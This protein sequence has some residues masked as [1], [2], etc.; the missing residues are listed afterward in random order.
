MQVFQ[1]I[2]Q[3]VYSQQAQQAPP[4]GGEPQGGE[5]AA[6]EDDVVEGEIVDEGDAEGSG[7]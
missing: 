6:P 2:G 4:G 7:S 5:G 3:A 1:R